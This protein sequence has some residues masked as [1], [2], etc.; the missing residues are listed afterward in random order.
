VAEI[1][2]DGGG[3]RAGRV[4]D[5][6]NTDLVQLLGP[7]FD[8]RRAPER[9]VQPLAVR[10][11]VET[12][13]VELS[14]APASTPA[15]SSEAALCLLAVEDIDGGAVGDTLGVRALTRSIAEH[16]LLQPLLVRRDGA[17]YRVISG[18]RRLVAAR[19]AG[20][21]KVPCVVRQVTADQ[22]AALSSASHADAGD[23]APS[24]QMLVDPDPA[25][26][27]Q[28]LARLAADLDL[29]ERRS[30]GISSAGSLD[31][32]LLEAL[33]E[34]LAAIQ[35]AAALLVVDNASMVQRVAV[36]LLR[37]QASRA[38][39][40]LRASVLV[41]G[42]GT[43]EVGLSRPI[44]AVL[45]AV[46]DMFAPEARLR[47]VDVRVNAPGWNESL[48]IDDRVL[49][50]GVTGGV[51]ATLGLLDGVKGGVIGLSAT[52]DPGRAI[53][54]QISQEAVGV[55]DAASS[56]FFDRGWVDRP[57]GWAAALGAS[58]VKICAE[59]HGG[60]ASLMVRPVAGTSV[61]LEFPARR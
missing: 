61:E 25:V 3:G 51:I 34:E 4:P 35:S 40:L 12:P 9:E 27:T 54:I 36:D 57:G 38:A 50:C 19:A 56:R 41:A 53:S 29:V 24:D 47:G 30:P 11:P 23:D 10:P 46:A 1:D 48:P 7:P 37:M 31:P 45:T 49:V 60:R 28:L 22:A 52:R 2:P 5:R 6:P 43:V 26:T 20:L 8:R 14:P 13:R 42:Q 15:S 16:G 32:R 18:E 21:T 55:P 44:G 58:V 59:R 33:T 17:R 39:W